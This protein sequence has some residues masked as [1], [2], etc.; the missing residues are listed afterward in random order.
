MDIFL[1][2]TKSDG[3]DPD[4]ENYRK[5]ITARSLNRSGGYTWDIPY[6]ERTES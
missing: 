2:F 6:R 1:A 4:G 3:L 5:R